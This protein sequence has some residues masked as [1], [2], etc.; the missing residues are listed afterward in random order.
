VTSASRRSYVSAS[1]TRATSIAESA[2]VAGTE[3]TD[4]YC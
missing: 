2:P 3:N 4:T 1:D